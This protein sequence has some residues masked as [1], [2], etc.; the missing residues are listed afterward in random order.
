MF[1]CVCVCVK[2]KG[3]PSYTA[4]CS[5][6]HESGKSFADA[7]HGIVLTCYY[8][9]KIQSSLPSCAAGAALCREADQTC[10]HAG[11]RLFMFFR[12]D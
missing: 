2:I 5:A 11:T 12:L 9:E 7:H 6:C 10:L 8:S 1:V 3:T 4:L